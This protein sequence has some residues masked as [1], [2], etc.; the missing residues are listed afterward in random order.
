ML[1]IESGNADIFGQNCEKVAVL[2][3][4][5][6]LMADDFLGGIIW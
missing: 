3:V 4:F 2:A 6:R 5:L 1:D